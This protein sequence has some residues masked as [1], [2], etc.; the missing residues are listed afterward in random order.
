MALILV[1]E[2]EHLV[3][4]SLVRRLEQCGHEVTAAADLAQAAGHLQGRSP[5][6]VLLDECLPDGSGLDFLEHNR[7]QL[8]NAAVV[9]TTAVSSGDDATRAERLGV[10]ALLIKPVEHRTLVELVER[11]LVASDP[12][13]RVTAPVPSANGR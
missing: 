2:N 6:V 3:R 8:A 13:T 7:D 4:W 10:K 5:D 1:V 12:A 11:C 9:M